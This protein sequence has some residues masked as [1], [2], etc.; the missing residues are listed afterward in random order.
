M[1][2]VV[3]MKIEILQDLKRIDRIGKEDR[4]GAEILDKEM[5]MTAKQWILKPMRLDE[6]KDLH[7]T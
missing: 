4:Y 6:C 2:R 3:A 7:L 1:N 5:K